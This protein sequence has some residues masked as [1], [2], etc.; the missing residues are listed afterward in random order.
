MM[1]IHDVYDVYD[2]DGDD[3]YSMMKMIY[4]DVDDD[5]V[6]VF[7]NVDGV[8]SINSF[9]LLFVCG[10]DIVLFVLLFITGGNC[11]IKFEV[12]DDDVDDDDGGGLPVKLSLIV[13]DNKL[14]DVCIAFDD[15]N[16]HDVVVVDNN[17]LNGCLL[18]LLVENG[19]IGAFGNSKLRCGNF[20]INF[21]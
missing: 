21:L 2:D 9:C 11:T 1:M 7:I 20:S 13:A 8:C 4:D 12:V 5:A 19:V 3:V 16:E 14:L 18:F 6:F 15:V 10:V 17:C